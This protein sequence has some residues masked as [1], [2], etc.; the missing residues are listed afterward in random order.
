M[1]FGEPKL[2][3]EPG[4]VSAEKLARLNAHIESR[5]ISKVLELAE[6]ES[7]LSFYLEELPHGGHRPEMYL[8]LKAWMNR[9]LDLDKDFEHAISLLS[10]VQFIQELGIFYEHLKNSTE[11]R[12]LIAG[13]GV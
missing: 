10:H 3:F 5:V 11:A 6:P 13:D 4:T 2:V 9:T 7:V 12:N 8:C 1:N